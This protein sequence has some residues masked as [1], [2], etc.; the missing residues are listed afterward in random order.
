M[1]IYLEES[2]D[3][4]TKQLLLSIGFTILDLTTGKILIHNIESSSSDKNLALD[5]LCKILSFFNPK[6][7]IINTSLKNI[8]YEFIN[9]Y[10]E[11]NKFN[12]I[13][14]TYF[15]KEFSRINYQ[16]ELIERIWKVESQLSGIEYFHLENLETVRISLIVAIC[17]SEEHNSSI[18]N[19][20]DI[21]KFLW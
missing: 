16:N 9:N 13:K 14:D 11:L 6:E 21:P 2:K 19:N 8:R 10:C 18:I 4:K 7:I 3:Y 5:E 1:S 12:I 15:K 20:L 17:F